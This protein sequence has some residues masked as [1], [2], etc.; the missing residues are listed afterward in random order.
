VIASPFTYETDA[1][2][3]CGR[4]VAAPP[5]VVYAQA[6][7]GAFTTQERA[8]GLHIVDAAGHSW[9]IAST[10]AIGASQISAMG[11]IAR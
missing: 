1:R 9:G 2:G 5:P 4:Y 8:D 11:R 10:P 6:E 3:R 7:T